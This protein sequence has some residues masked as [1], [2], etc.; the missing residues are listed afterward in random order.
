MKGI[1]TVN[2]QAC[3]VLPPFRL[4]QM[5]ATPVV[6]LKETPCVMF[7]LTFNLKTALNIKHIPSKGLSRSQQQIC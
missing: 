1:L 7:W 5:S 4:C 3:Q 6:R 2:L